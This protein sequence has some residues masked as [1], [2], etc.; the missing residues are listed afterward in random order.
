MS[1]EHRIRRPECMRSR[2]WVKAGIALILPT[3]IGTQDKLCG[4]PAKLGR[5]ILDG[6]SMDFISEEAVGCPSCYLGFGPSILLILRPWAMRPLILLMQ[7]RMNS[8]PKLLNVRTSNPVS[9]PANR[10][11]RHVKW[12]GVLILKQYKLML[13]ISITGMRPRRG[14]SPMRPPRYALT[15]R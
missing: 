4:G 11:I 5:Y 12:K 10:Y 13:I 9:I 3:K 2:T 1:P 14:L 7:L 15:C 6:S 8:T